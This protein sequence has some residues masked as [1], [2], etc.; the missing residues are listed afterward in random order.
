ML[1]TGTGTTLW[2]SY[3]LLAYLLYSEFS[4]QKYS[5]IWQDCFAGSGKFSQQYPC[6]TGGLQKAAPVRHSFSVSKTVFFFVLVHPDRQSIMIIF[7][8]LVLTS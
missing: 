5:T 2:L 3:I 6:P 4:G 1:I 8:L 7:L